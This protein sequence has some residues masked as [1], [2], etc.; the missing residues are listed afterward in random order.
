MLHLGRSSRR[1]V[2]VGLV[3]SCVRCFTHCRACVCVWYSTVSCHVA[4]NSACSCQRTDDATLLLRERV[5]LLDLHTHTHT[6]TRTHTR[7][8]SFSLYSRTFSQTFSV[9]CRGHCLTIYFSFTRRWF[10]LGTGAFL[11]VFYE[12]QVK[13]TGDVKKSKKVLKD[14]IKISVKLGLLYRHN[15]FSEAE[16]GA[17]GPLWECGRVGGCGSRHRVH[18]RPHGR[19]YLTVL[20]DRSTKAGWCLA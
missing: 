19:S 13:Y 8:L 5:N 10:F 12:L 1:V 7:T 14:M 16:L 11:D 6:H 2:R 18:S 20:R 4:D 9:P 17:L 3:T 15:Q